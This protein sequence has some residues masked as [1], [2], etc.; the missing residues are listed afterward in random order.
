MCYTMYWYI[1]IYELLTSTCGRYAGKFVRGLMS[2]TGAVYD[3][4]LQ[5]HKAKLP[6]CQSP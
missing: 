2:D 5:L 1:V 4:E 3:V 6:S